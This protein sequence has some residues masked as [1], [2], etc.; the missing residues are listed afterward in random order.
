MYSV[1]LLWLYILL[2]I[3]AILSKIF[4]FSIVF[5]SHETH[6]I[7]GFQVQTNQTALTRF[8]YLLY[9][10][11]E[12]GGDKVSLAFPCEE[13]SMTNTSKQDKQE[14]GGKKGVDQ[15]VHKIHLL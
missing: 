11:Q 6:L 9:F 15:F 5:F 10:S 13:M 4:L 8:V 2:F 3:K 7:S 14:F 12:R 1:K